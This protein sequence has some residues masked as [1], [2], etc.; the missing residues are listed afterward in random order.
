M[1]S[2]WLW[3]LL[4]VHILSFVILSSLILNDTNPF[5][6][7][8]QELVTTAPHIRITTTSPTITPDSLKSHTLRLSLFSSD[9]CSG[10][11][12]VH[13][14]SSHHE[15]RCQ[16]CWDLCNL[17]YDTTQAQVHQRAGSIRVDASFGNE[18]INL[19][20]S[21][22]GTYE[23]GSQDVYS[24][25][26]SITAR[27]GCVDLSDFPVSHVEFFDRQV[28]QGV[29]KP[30][31]STKPVNFQVKSN[32]FTGSYMIVYNVEDKEYFRWQVRAHYHSY[33][34][35]KQTG[36]SYMRLLSGDSYD[37]ISEFVPTYLTPKHPSAGAYSPL[38]KPHSI[39]MWLNSPNAPVEDVLV[40][41][42]PDNWLI[43]D[44]SP[45]VSRVRRGVAIGQSAW[46]RGS[47]EVDEIWR[48]VCE[49]NCQLQTTDHVAVPLFIH[50][51]DMKEIAPLW[52]HYT[53]KVRKLARKDKEFAARFKHNQVIGWSVEMIGYVFAAAHVGV[54]HVIEGYLQLRDVD[55]RPVQSVLDEIPMIHMGR[56]W[57]PAS[58]EPGR[59]WWHT[60]GKDFRHFGMQVWCKCNDTAG[61]I[62]PWPL[63]NNADYITRNTL[64][65]LH[66]SIEAFGNMF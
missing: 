32:D 11:E 55:A 27:D 60:E 4:V 44:L 64:T 2:W 37:D 22:V 58:Y 23:Y 10:D 66:D 57:F 17:R 56:A 16:E 52:T 12:V 20:G 3:C 65:I 33:I 46:F 42:D 35:S 63:P 54:R 50:R 24:P 13:L 39:D 5:S 49:R 26:I 53:M 8:Q 21:C 28:A 34:Q 6:T 43:K 9:D 18:K 29:R 38:N 40:I 61:E 47:G 36:G 59:K 1:R 62:V 41:V 19:L 48:I 14:Y 15:R 25:L 45:F 7:R 30:I 31:S 51:D